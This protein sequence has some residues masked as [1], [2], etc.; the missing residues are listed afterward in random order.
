MFAN[1]HSEIDLNKGIPTIKSFEENLDN[2]TVNIHLE[3]C[4]LVSLFK[5]Y[6]RVNL[7]IDLDELEVFIILDAKNKRLVLDTSEL[8]ENDMGEL[9]YLLD[10]FKY[11]F[12]KSI[13]EI[14]AIINTQIL[15]RKIIS[16]CDS[17]MWNNDGSIDIEYS[18]YNITEDEL[19]K[20][21]NL[22]GEC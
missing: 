1:V 17:Y 6:V 4:E 16:N 15:F 18:L 12:G 21:L 13:F 14:R 20:Y 2:F 8:E 3:S 11:H 22:E 19:N 7:D 5:N 9:I 10:E